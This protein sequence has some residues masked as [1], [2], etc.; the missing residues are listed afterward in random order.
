MITSAFGYGNFDGI[1]LVYP[2]H[3]KTEITSKIARFLAIYYS[4]L[5]NIA[6]DVLTLETMFEK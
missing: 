2:K 1:D 3:V 6:N 4:G 5:E